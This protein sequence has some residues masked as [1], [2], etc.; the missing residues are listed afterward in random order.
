MGVWHFSGLGNSPGALTVPLTYIYLILKAA[1]RGD[2]MARRFFEASG[3]ESQERKGAPEALIIFTSREIIEGE[4]MSRDIRDDWF[5]TPTGSVPAVISKYFSKLF[6]T[7]RNATFSEFYEEGWIRYIHFIAVNHTELYDC[8]PKCYATMNALR[9]KEIWINM[10]AGTNPINASLM[11]SAGFV[12]ANARTYYIFEPD[13][14]SIHPK[15]G[16]VDFSNPSVG[17]LLSR[18]NIL[19][20]FSLDLGKLVRGLNEIFSGDRTIANIAEIYSLLNRL[21]FPKQYFKKLVSGG[22][23]KTEGNTAKV[24]EMLERWNK[25]LGRIGEYPSNYSEWK[26]WA[27]KEEILYNLTLD[28]NVEKVRP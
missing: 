21:E 17:P 14:R 16:P 9:E 28:G 27:S 22:W 26:K 1:S 24:G 5:R 6:G 3:E 23:I 10:V 20:F 18:L 2:L 11:L 4:S 19:P 13:T 25:M 7:L 12:E 8:F 15:I